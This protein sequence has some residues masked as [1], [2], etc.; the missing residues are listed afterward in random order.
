MSKIHFM[1]VL[2]VSPYY[3][4]KGGIASVIFNYNSNSN[5]KFNYFFSMYFKSKVF[6][7]L[8]FPF[9]MFNFLLKI[10]DP[11]IAIVHLHCAKKGSF[12]RKYF[13]FKVS[14]I[15]KKK[16]VFHIH[17]G[18]FYS[19][20]LSSNILIQK[21]VNEVLE[22]SD[23]VIVL[24]SSWKNFY[25]DHF[26]CSNLNVV[27]N[28][29]P[30][31]SKRK[32][33]IVN[34]Q[35]KFL[36]LGELSNRKGIYDVINVIKQNINVLN[37]KIKLYVAGDGDENKINKILKDN[38]LE[39][40]ITILG[41]IDG[42]KK[43]HLLENIDIVIL[44]S[45]AEGMPIALLE[46]ISFSKPII[47]SKINGIID[48]LKDNVNGKLIKPGDYDSILNAIFYYVKNRDLI[49][50]HANESYKIANKFFP[51]NVFNQLT[52]LYNSI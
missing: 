38:K 50:A 29:T 34:K 42:D 46:A 12:Y 43:T 51:K 52:N 10:T 20:Y 14:K 44:P 25:S 9:L 23:S 11:K 32:N 18:E 1:N 4:L 35:L 31:Q 2:H 45:Y 40:H 30:F 15:F 41:W 7:F 17:S 33:I 22:K 5:E 36:F 24:S 16:I 27:N 13:L 6:N 21:M 8:V 49:P 39:D 47:A 26:N 48:I 3:K 28:L 19:F 37:K